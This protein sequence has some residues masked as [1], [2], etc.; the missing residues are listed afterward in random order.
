MTSAEERAVI[1]RSFENMRMAFLLLRAPLVRSVRVQRDAD[2][3]PFEH[4]RDEPGPAVDLDSHVADPPEDV[5]ARPIDED[6]TRQ[7]ET[8]RAT[9]QKKIQAFPLQQSGPLRDETPFEPQI[10]PGARSPVACDPQRHVHL[11]ATRTPA[12]PYA[13]RVPGTHYARRMSGH[14]RTESSLA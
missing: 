5:D 12:G 10:R 2:A 8:H 3:L 7:V 13:R 4:A 1:R 14:R 11:L 6:D 9:G